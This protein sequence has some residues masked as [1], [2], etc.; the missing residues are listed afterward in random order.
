MSIAVFLFPLIVRI[1]ELFQVSSV[2]LLLLDREFLRRIE[3]DCELDFD[4]FRVLNGSVDLMSTNGLPL[5]SPVSRDQT[6]GVTDLNEASG[7]RSVFHSTDTNAHDVV[8]RRQFLW[9]NYNPAGAVGEF[10]IN[11]AITMW[12]SGVVLVINQLLAI[13]IRIG[14]G[15]FA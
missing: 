2:G 9:R 8:S 1:P 3:S 11:A 13:P 7:S 4:R 14:S 15:S 6:L 10:Q 5:E 12:Q